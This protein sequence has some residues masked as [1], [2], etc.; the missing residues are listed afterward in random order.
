[1]HS[2]LEQI[3]TTLEKQRTATMAATI[4]PGAVNLASFCQ[5]IKS[6]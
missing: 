6:T 3:V 2:L 5:K 1:M 4:A